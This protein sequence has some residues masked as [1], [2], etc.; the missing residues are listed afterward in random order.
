[1]VCV[2]WPEACWGTLLPNPLAE[3]ERV[4]VSNIASTMAAIMASNPSLPSLDLACLRLLSCGGSPQPDA[5]VRRCIAQFGC[6]FFVS[7][8]MTGEIGLGLQL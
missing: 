8:G 4:T 1:M 5:V 2:A 6:E 7:Y 3:L